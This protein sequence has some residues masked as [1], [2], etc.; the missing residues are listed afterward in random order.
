MTLR[1]AILSSYGLQL[2]EKLTEKKSIQIVMEDTGL[3]I[4]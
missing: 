3:K 2:K 1:D 4:T